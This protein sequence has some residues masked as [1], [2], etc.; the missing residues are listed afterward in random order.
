M[1][2]LVPSLLPRVRVLLELS[3]ALVDLRCS[4]SS[5]PGAGSQGRAGVS[6]TPFPLPPP[7]WTRSPSQKLRDSAP[8]GTSPS[9][10]SSS[11]PPDCRAYGPASFRPFPLRPFNQL[12]SDRVYLLM[13]SE[14]PKLPESQGP[15]IRC[16]AFVCRSR[17]RVD[18]SRLCQCLQSSLTLCDGPPAASAD[19]LSLAMVC[20]EQ[21]APPCAKLSTPALHCGW[22]LSHSVSLNE[23]RAP[24]E[25]YEY[26]LG[27]PCSS[28]RESFSR[29]TTSRE[30]RGWQIGGYR[31]G[32]CALG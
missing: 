2:P 11:Q 26:P 29:L 30:N 17:F 23:A 6:T 4:S 20:K 27:C 21:P 16:V 13:T 10:P 28:R 19:R 18:T 15:N 22:R 7:L 3:T 1:Q 9:P 8:I 12:P 24:R 31:R 5:S 14:T 32:C 25:C